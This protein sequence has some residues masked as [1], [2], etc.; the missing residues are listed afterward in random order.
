VERMDGGMGEGGKSK[1]QQYEIYDLQ[2]KKCR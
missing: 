2:S 1:I